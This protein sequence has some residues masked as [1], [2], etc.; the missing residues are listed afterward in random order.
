M[1][2]IVIKT[3]MMMLVCWN[4]NK[5]T[6]LHLTTS[7]VCFQMALPRNGWVWWPQSNLKACTSAI[8]YATS[9][10]LSNRPKSSPGCL[11]CSFIRLYS[12]QLDGGV[13]P[14]KC[15]N[16]DIKLVNCKVINISSFH[17]FICAQFAPGVRPLQESSVISKLDNGRAELSQA[18]V[19]VSALGF[20]CYLLKGLL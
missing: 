15:K 17:S 12:H 19:F 20:I 2:P 3:V 1:T 10:F 8:V 18:T 5:N 14:Q 9:H 16:R 6:H 11:T 7:T 4:I 13:L